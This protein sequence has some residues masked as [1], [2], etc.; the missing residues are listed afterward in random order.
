MQVEEKK[1][2]NDFE[3][4][5]DTE[6]ARIWRTDTHNFRDQEKDITEKVLLN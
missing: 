4:S 3:K 1:R 2:M 5:L 6:Q